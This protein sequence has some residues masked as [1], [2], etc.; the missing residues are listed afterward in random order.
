MRPVCV[1]D[2]AD[3]ELTYTF[4]AQKEPG[5]STKGVREMPVN[6]YLRKF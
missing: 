1:F 6:N 4:V 5:G 3:L 2:I